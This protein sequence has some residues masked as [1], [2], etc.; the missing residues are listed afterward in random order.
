[1]SG[2][3]LYATRTSLFV[4]AVSFL[5]ATWTRE[6]QEARRPRL[7]ISSTGRLGPGR[8]G[9]GGARVRPAATGADRTGLPTL[10]VLQL[11][12][13][14]PMRGMPTTRHGRLPPPDHVSRWRLTP[15]LIVEYR[16]SS[17]PLT[18]HST[19]YIVISVANPICLAQY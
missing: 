15:G 5:T 17:R 8:A 4:V 6:W 11:D 1:M 10:P 7:A 19:K 18:K 3:V 12:L 13:P 9:R 2:T 16:A 14:G